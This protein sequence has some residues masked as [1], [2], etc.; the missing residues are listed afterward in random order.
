MAQF[1]Q[2]GTEDSDIFLVGNAYVSTTAGTFS[3]LVSSGIGVNTP[4][5]NIPLSDYGRSVGQFAPGSFMV[6][7]YHWTNG[8]NGST[9]IGVDGGWLLRLIDANGIPRF[10]IALPLPISGAVYGPLIMQTI[11]AAGQFTQVGGSFTGLVGS[12]LQK[13]SVFWTTGGVKVY[14]GS[15]LVAGY[16]GDMTTDGVDALAGYDLGCVTRGGNSPVG[17]SVWSGMKVADFDVRSVELM[18]LTITGAGATSS[19][20][21]AS[22]GSTIDEITMNIAD[23][24]DS[25]T[26]NQISLF[27]APGTLPTG[28]WGILGIGVAAFCSAA[29]YA[30]IVTLDTSADTASGATLPFTSTTGVADGQLVT[31]TNIAPGA[32]VLSFVANTSVTLTANVL[33]DV[34][35]G[36]AITFTTQSPQ[37]IDMALHIGSTT[38]V[39]PPQN[40]DPS[41]DRAAYVWPVSPATGQLVTSTELSG[42]QVGVKSIA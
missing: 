39:S 38:Y 8:E 40:V 15:A 30:A 5:N 37:H 14:I 24:I 26:D 27:T 9:T 1:L 35:S 6:S 21:G 11:N 33:G 31:G 23:G 29:P 10:Q 7:G 34:P 25:E 2:W 41:L 22:D 36:E 32:T 17:G 20:N 4:G 19:W 42:L 18:K 3:P 12:T 28:T 13:L 16:A